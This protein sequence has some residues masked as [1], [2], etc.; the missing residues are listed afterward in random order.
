M[1]SSPPTTVLVSGASGIVGYGIL[2][3]LR[4]STQPL[5]LIGTSIYDDSVAPAFCDH[6][7]LAPRTQELAY[8]DW[9]LSVSKKHKVDVLIP[10]IE[11]DVYLWSN[12]REQLIA[13]GFRF[14]LNTPD[15]LTNTQDKWV[16]YQTLESIDCPYRIPSSL[17]DRWEAARTQFGSPLLLKPRQGYA[18]RGIVRVDSLAQWSS[19]QHR[20]GSEL[21]VQRFVGRTEAEFTVSAFGDGQGNVTASIALRRELSSEGFTLKAESF[22]IE[23]FQPAI[24]ELSAHFKPLGP[25]NFQFRLEND[26][27][28]LLE[29]NPRISSSV[30]IRSLLGYNE[31]LMA[32]NHALDGTLPQQPALRSGRAIRYWEDYVVLNDHPD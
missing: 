8:L 28:Y 26:R 15:L 31:P 6:F 25:T 20:I 18:S 5:H 9:L 32:L 3:C 14:I 19:H 17:D 21:M 30:S 16:F 27:L 12:F 11:A 4:Q 22:P 10:G 23:R 7:E 13:S 29:I 1:G 24:N 2:K